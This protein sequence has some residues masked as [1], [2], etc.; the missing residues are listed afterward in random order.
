M[1]LDPAKATSSEFGSSEGPVALIL[2]LFPNLEVL[3]WFEIVTYLVTAAKPM[4]QTGQQ[5]I[6]NSHTRPTLQNINV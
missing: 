1:S 5:L 6:E 4:V 2:H 3:Q